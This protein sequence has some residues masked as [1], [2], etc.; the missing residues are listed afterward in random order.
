MYNENLLQAKCIN[1]ISPNEAFANKV[2]DEI[3]GSY[4]AQEQN[5]ILRVIIANIKTNR[6]KMCAEANERLNLLTSTYK[7]IEA[8]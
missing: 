7:E 1:P 3:I 5:E 6:A 8:L 2:S 4:L